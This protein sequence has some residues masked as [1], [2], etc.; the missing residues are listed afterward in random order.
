M[1]PN[2]G[3]APVAISYRVPRTRN[4][5]WHATSLMKA[6]AALAEIAFAVGFF[7]QGHLARHFRHR[8]G[9]TPT[10]VSMVSTLETNDV[11]DHALL[12]KNR[13]N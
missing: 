10:R 5:L 6:S 9:T 7:D 3:A 13:C 11:S 12:A 8:L 1:I 4:L 2:T